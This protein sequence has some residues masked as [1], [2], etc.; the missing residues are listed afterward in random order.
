MMSLINEA[1]KKAEREKRA[2]GAPFATYAAMK[3]AIVS[4]PA[5]RRGGRLVKAA[6]LLSVPVVCAVVYLA[7]NAATSGR[8]QT[9][10]ASLGDPSLTGSSGAAD[11]LLV[12]IGEG[13]TGMT[14]ATPTIPAGTVR[15]TQV[16]AD[17]Q[18][19]LVVA[20]APAVPPGAVKAV[21]AQAGA[22]AGP[23]AVPAE[24][25]LLARTAEAPQAPKAPA[26]TKD[27]FKLTAIMRGPDGATAIVNGQFVGVG[28]TVDKAKVTKIGTHSV[29]LQADDVKLSIQM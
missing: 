22:A 9:V 12:T 5:R 7:V 6:V 21:A 3:E 1:L 27:D 29:D 11:R 23:D 16:P 17:P 2:N 28:D 24:T 4:P 26:I 10:T 14:I 25:A 8:A 13:G 18:P 19:G 20:G 15:S